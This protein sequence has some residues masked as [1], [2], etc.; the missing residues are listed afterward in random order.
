MLRRS[1]LDFRVFTEQQCKDL[2][3]AALEV[4]E[5]VGVEIHSEQALD[6]A[7]APHSSWAA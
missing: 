1:N 2:H 4:L 5:R 3:S 7:K 6:V